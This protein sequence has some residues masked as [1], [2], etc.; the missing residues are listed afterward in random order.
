MILCGCVLQQQ[1][2]QQRYTTLSYMS[3]ELSLFNNNIV[4]SMPGSLCQQGN[5]SDPAPAVA[6]A[7][8]LEADC[9]A[10][11]EGPAQIECDCCTRCCNDQRCVDHA[12]R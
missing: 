6:A 3:V 9:L 5:G 2:M 7:T 8:F 4:G 1:N 12:S 10:V 11:P